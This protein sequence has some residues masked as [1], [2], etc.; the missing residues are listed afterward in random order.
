MLKIKKILGISLAVLC[1][2]SI[3]VTASSACSCSLHSYLFKGDST[4][5]SI[6]Q[7]RY[8]YSL[9]VGSSGNAVER[10]QTALIWAG[11]P[12]PN[13]GAD[14]IFG[15]ETYNAVTAYQSKHGLQVDG[16][17]GPCTLCNLDSYAAWY[18]SKYMY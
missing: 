16:K 3:T 9:H 1:L 2:L 7:G 6:S 14:G 10:V 4:L 15:S 8:P 18:E 13:Y 17:V 12:L 5:Q 11:C